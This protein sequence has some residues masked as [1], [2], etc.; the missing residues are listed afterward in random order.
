MG[1]KNTVHYGDLN[2]EV[3]MELP[4]KLVAH[5][6]YDKVC[7]FRESL[8]RLKQSPCAWFNKLLIQIPQTEKDQRY[9][10]NDLTDLC[11]DK[12]ES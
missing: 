7:Q 5:G 6:E 3:Y 10:K 4:L 8:Y 12:Q 2:E 9:L 1:F 11:E